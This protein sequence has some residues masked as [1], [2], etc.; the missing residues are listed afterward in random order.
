MSNKNQY[1]DNSKKEWDTF[2]QSPENEKKAEAWKNQNSVNSWRHSRMRDIVSPLVQS[3][4]RAKWLTVGDGRYGSDAVG[5]MSIGVQSVHA[6]D[7]SKTL[8]AV[9]KK[10][11]EIRHFSEENAEEL[12]FADD[13]FDFVYCKEAYH[14]FPRAYKALHEMFRVSQTGVVLIEP[15]D[16]AIDRAT[17]AFLYNIIKTVFYRRTEH[18]CFESVGN[19]V[20]SISEREIEKFA[21]GMNC[22][23]VAFYSINDAYIPG[24]EY[25]ELNSPKLSDKILRTK[26]RAKIF[27]QNIL[28]WLRLRSSGLLGVI[29]FK[30]D[31]T[32]SVVFNLK[33]AGWKVVSLP[34]NPYR[35]N[36]D[37]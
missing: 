34:K 31:V 36:L 5:L 6:S 14:H 37:L 23:T 22:K 21:L 15:R 8:L 12:S 11:G 16:L 20:Y 1:Q 18:D 19:Y 7:L 3:F 26:I 13:E 33:K 9:A 28:V 30:S 2:Q 29:I 4:A 17:F 27:I 24:V 25:S 35:Q 10:K 32:D